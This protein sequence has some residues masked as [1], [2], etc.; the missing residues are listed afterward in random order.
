MAPLTEP[1]LP[2][3]CWAVRCPQQ[4]SSPATRKPEKLLSPKS[5]HGRLWRKVKP[6]AE[7]RAAITGILCPGSCPACSGPQILL[8]E[9]LSRQDARCLQ[10][11]SQRASPSSQQ[12]G[13]TP[14]SP[15]P[16]Y[17][18]GYFCISDLQCW[19]KPWKSTSP[20]HSFHSRDNQ[21]TETKKRQLEATY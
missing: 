20:T 15:K 9:L 1:G 18:F 10:L 19:K 4:I 3:T 21:G 6:R 8:A 5:I 7:A 12:M 11:L 14:G 2:H 16:L 17:C 13:S